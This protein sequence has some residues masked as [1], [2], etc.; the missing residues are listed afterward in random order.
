[1]ALSANGKALGLGVDADY[2]GVDACVDFPRG[3]MAH[4]CPLTSFQ[5]YGGVPY[6]RSGMRD[7]LEVSSY[8]WPFSGTC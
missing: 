1:M 6:S 5:E 4:P 2:K 7:D 3:V 8:P